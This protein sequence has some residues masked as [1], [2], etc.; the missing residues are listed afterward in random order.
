MKIAIIG[1]REFK[2]KKLFEKIMY[3]EID[4]RDKIITGGAKGV[5]TWVEEW[6]KKKSFPLNP[7]ITVIKPINPKDK[8]S[9]L[10]RNIEIITLADKIFAF[11]DG[12]S[13]GTK[14]VID[15]ATSRDKNMVVIRE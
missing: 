4:I 12:E 14:F 13:K 11:W 9:Y 1:S 5:D 15:Y 10:F 6:V 2:N 8:L 7:N 3:K